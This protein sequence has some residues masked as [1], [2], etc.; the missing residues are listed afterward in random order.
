MCACHTRIMSIPSW[1]L[2]PVDPKYR[3]NF[4]KSPLYYVNYY[5]ANNK[6]KTE[7][8]FFHFI[9]SP[10]LKAFLNEI[11]LM[12]VIHVV[13]DI[14]SHIFIFSRT[15]GSVTTKLNTSLHRQKDSIKVVQ[16]KGQGQ[17]FFLWG[18]REIT[19]KSL[20]TFDNF[21]LFEPC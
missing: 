17:T 6:H 16:L 14:L 12:S 18:N 5:L 10:E 20:R 19:D 9:S 13:V 21:L 1:W 2:R 3:G 8:F 11:C 7:G 4:N 15:T